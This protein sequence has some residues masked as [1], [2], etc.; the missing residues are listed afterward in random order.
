M[1]SNYPLDDDR[2][3]EQV[4]ESGVDCH[5]ATE[6]TY[7]T[8]VDFM[9]AAVYDTA[10]T[11]SIPGVSTV[12]VNSDQEVVSD[13]SLSVLGCTYIVQGYHDPW[14]KGCCCRVQHQR[15]VL[16]NVSMHLRAGEVTGIMGNSGEFNIVC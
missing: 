9:P 12:T 6:G 5:E 4:V 16:Q 14:W 1:A 3:R 2:V 11:Q 10:E 15:A 7:T 13:R 8:A